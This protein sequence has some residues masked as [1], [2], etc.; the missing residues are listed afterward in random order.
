MGDNALRTMASKSDNTNNIERN[1]VNPSI[2]ISHFVNVVVR[3]AGAC[4]HVFCFWCFVCF[5]LVPLPLAIPPLLFC[6]LISTS[7]PSHPSLAQSLRLE[8]LSLFICSLSYLQTL[9]S[10]RTTFYWI[11]MTT[12]ETLFL[13]LILFLSLSSLHAHILLF[14]YAGCLNRYMF[15]SFC[16][17]IYFH[18]L[19]IPFILSI[20]NEHSWTVPQHSNL[21]RAYS[22]LCFFIGQGENQH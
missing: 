3:C 9:F 5:Y 17:H 1:F 4:M 14:S 11:S 10:V 13:S 18:T 21:F 22:V 7:S 19:K 20:I 15:F 12:M 6:H 16:C 2:T 8:N